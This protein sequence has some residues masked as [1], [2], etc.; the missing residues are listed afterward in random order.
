MILSYMTC[1]WD[2]VPYIRSVPVEIG[3]FSSVRFPF[4]I[5][6][7]VHNINT[8]YDVYFL[9]PHPTTGRLETLYC[10]FGSRLVT[11]VRR[12]TRPCQGV[13]VCVVHG[14]TV[15]WSHLTRPLPWTSLPSPV[16]DNVG[17][18]TCIPINVLMSLKVPLAIH[19]SHKKLVMFSQ[20][21]G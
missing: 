12:S 6:G 7:F 16:R 11:H 8:V 19:F 10:H 3:N 18:V 17:G 21:E 2:T 9:Y 4:C 5:N 13:C 1:V 14:Y 15:Y 20:K